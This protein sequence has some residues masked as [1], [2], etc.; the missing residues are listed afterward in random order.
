MLTWYVLHARM[1]DWALS[2]PANTHYVWLKYFSWKGCLQNSLSQLL[3]QIESSTQYLCLWYG[4]L[5]NLCNLTKI[6]PP[7]HSPTSATTQPSLPHPNT[8]ISTSPK[9]TLFHLT[10]THPSP[11][12]PNTPISTS[13]KHTYLHLKQNTLILTP[14]NP[15][16]TSI[17]Q[18]QTHQ[19]T[20]ITPPQPHHTHPQNNYLK[21]K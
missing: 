15:M 7:I 1:W 10:Q 14:N 16:L 20:T 12:H 9:H 3:C 11:P 18:P 5:H 6:Y 13:P 19:R 2:W 17:T 21:W 8:P 4:F